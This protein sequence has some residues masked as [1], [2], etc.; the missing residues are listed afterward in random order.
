MLSTGPDMVDAYN[1]LQHLWL[2]VQDLQKLKAV[3][4]LAWPSPQRKAMGS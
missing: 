4:L 1:N 2:S 3:K